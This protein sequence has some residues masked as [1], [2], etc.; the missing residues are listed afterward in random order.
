MPLKATLALFIFTFSL[1]GCHKKGSSAEE[2]PVQVE[3]IANTNN[4]EQPVIT[5]PSVSTLPPSRSQLN[6]VF[7]WENVHQMPV[8]PGNP[9]VAV[10]WSNEAIRNYDPGLRYDY[11][12]SDGWELVY[13]SFS[14]SQNYDNRI[15]ILY[16]KFRGVMRF[17]MYNTIPSN[18]MVDSYRSLINEISISSSYNIS[19]P[20]LN[21]AGQYIVD[22][23]APVTNTSLIEPWP[24]SERG[25][26]ISQ[27]ELAYDRYITNYNW[28]QFRINWAL[29]FARVEE[30]SLN[31]TPSKNKLVY[32][33]KPRFRFTDARGIAIGEN[34][35]VHVKTSAGFDELSGI[36]D[37][38]TINKLKQTVVDPIGG[39]FLNATLVPTLGIT[40]CKLDV[41][42]LIRTDYNLVGFIN[43]SMA[44]PG[45]DNSQIV[46][47]GPLFNEPP[48]IFY[49]GKKPV[50]TH[51]KTAAAL[52]EHYSL[53]IPALEYVINPFIQQY[54]TV[55]NF[56]QE[57]VAIETTDKRNLT[58]AKLYKG[59]IL[60]AS[61]PL[62]ILGVRVSFE[63]VPNN[64]SAPIKII[65]TFKADMQ[66]G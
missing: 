28:E 11:K 1:T 15:F 21:F 49:L 31:N 34:M 63:V 5:I 14:N 40:D 48:G 42:A 45:T 18:S 2:L 32:L 59:S 29:A 46:G 64:G 65:K 44:S 19:S 39:N 33:E 62:I 20:L 54:A 58:E 52:S 3:E 26:Y 24:I 12:K 56:Y 50:V 8:A 17:Y 38:A 47:F 30:L 10:P 25:W 61:A 41:M 22:M 36:F 35:Q 7:D 13:N 66:E 53:N 37:G 27:F 51:T 57:L 16:N 60:K 23:N 6:Y 9:A 55:R 43:L 4:Q